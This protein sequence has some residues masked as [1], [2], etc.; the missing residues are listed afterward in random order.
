MKIAYIGTSDG[1]AETLAERMVQEGNDIYLLSDKAFP[2]IG[3]AW[4]QRGCG[5]PMAEICRLDAQRG[6]LSEYWAC[7]V[8][9]VVH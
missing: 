6:G 2:R 5:E 4:P 8:K 3:G 9:P 1:L 7:R